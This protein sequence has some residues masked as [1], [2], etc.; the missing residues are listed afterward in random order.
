MSDTV[1]TVKRETASKFLLSQ[2][3]ICQQD[4]MG[5]EYWSHKG[6]RLLPIYEALE[7]G[8]EKFLFFAARPTGVVHLPDEADYAE[9]HH[10]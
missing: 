3:W 1:I 9:P 5:A 10:R 2:G 6:G 4:K 7:K 8:L